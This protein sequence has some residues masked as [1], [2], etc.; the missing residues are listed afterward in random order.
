MFVRVSKG[1]FAADKYDEMADRLKAA[2]DVLAPEIRALPGLI[3]YYAGMDR[4][5]NSMI[6]VSIWDR[7]EHADAM[8]GLK[9]VTASREEFAAAGV[10]WEPINTYDVS[11]WV[12]SP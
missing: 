7:R 6:R 4:D 3:D 5:S 11:W 10:D 8:S 9:Q 1:R 2:E 12:Q